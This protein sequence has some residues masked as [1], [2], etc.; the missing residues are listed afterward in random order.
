M[1]SYIFAMFLVLLGCILNCIK[2][3]LVEEGVVC[4]VYNDSG[5]DAGV[6]KELTRRMR[7]IPSVYL[8]IV[9]DRHALKEQLVCRTIQFFILTFCGRSCIFSESSFYT[10][11]RVCSYFMGYRQ[12]SFHI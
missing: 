7:N 6:N 1:V 9:Y 10:L 8:S 5:N 3:L 4:I 12:L 2:Q 11:Q